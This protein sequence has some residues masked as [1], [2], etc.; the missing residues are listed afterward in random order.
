M[1]KFELGIRQKI[2]SLMI[3]RM[4]ENDEIVSRYMDDLEFQ[5]EIFPLLAKEI[6]TTIR[7]ERD[8][9]SGNVRSPD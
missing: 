7:E 6:F 4:S 2:E 5:N 1:D 8:S 9:E 3:Q